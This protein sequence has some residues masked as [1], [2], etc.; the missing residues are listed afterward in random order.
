VDDSRP[1]TTFH[2]STFVCRGTCTGSIVHGIALMY[3]ACNVYS[4]MSSACIYISF[5]Y[6]I[7]ITLASVFFFICAEIYFHPLNKFQENQV[8]ITFNRFLL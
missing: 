5:N 6:I 1:L 4:F 8:Y 2:Q 3:S 7:S